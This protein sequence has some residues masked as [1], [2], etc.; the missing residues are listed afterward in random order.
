MRKWQETC[1]SLGIP[2]VCMCPA[3]LA[4]PSDMSNCLFFICGSQIGGKA[5]CSRISTARWRELEPQGRGHDVSVQ[6]ASPWAR[7]NQFGLSSEVDAAAQAGAFLPGHPVHT[8][9]VVVGDV[10]HRCIW[11][12]LGMQPRPAP[13][14]PL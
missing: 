9:T 7:R 1:A 12:G 2:G 8:L 14:A 6:V 13:Q 10:K 11:Q 5:L 3:H 4:V